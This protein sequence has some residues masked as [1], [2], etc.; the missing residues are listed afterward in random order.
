MALLLLPSGLA[1]QDGL[2]HGKISRDAG[3]YTLTIVTLSVN[4]IRA[5]ALLV[6]ADST[7]FTLSPLRSDTSLQGSFHVEYGLYRLTAS[8]AHAMAFASRV[9]LAVLGPNP[10]RGIAQYGARAP[11]RALFDDPESAPEQT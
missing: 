7:R 3:G 8:Q 1:A 4:P 6:Y 2:L 9:A 5:T 10:M 11:W